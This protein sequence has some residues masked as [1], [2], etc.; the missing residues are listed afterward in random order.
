MIITESI[1]SLKV[2]E[3][4]IGDVMHDGNLKVNQHDLRDRRRSSR[5]GFSSSSTSLNL[6]HNK[7]LAC[8]NIEKRLQWSFPVKLRQLFVLVTFPG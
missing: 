2:L 3:V 8:I 1:D 7:L 6:L 4:F 5:F